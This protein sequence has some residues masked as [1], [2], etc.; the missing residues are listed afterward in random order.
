[1]TGS[2]QVSGVGRQGKLRHSDTIN[3]ENQALNR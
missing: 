1:M 3:P 2:V